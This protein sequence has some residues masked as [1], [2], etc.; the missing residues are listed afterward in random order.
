MKIRTRKY[1]VDRMC[2]WYTDELSKMFLNVPMSLTT[3]IRMEQ[4]LKQLQKQQVA[5]EPGNEIWKFPVVLKQ[6]PPERGY[7][8]QVFIEKEFEKN[9]LYLDWPI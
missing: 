6:L 9:L 3:F 4:A 5:R 2:L 8:I 1:L 7:G